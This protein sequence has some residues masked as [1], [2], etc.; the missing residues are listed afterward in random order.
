[1]RLPWKKIKD[2]RKII[3]AMA[4]CS[5]FIVDIGWGKRIYRVR[6]FD[7]SETCR[8]VADLGAARMADAITHALRMKSGKS[9]ISALSVPR[10]IE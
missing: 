8:Y 9:H 4:R 7:K 2:D 1:M 6:M 10:K 5:Y 3:R